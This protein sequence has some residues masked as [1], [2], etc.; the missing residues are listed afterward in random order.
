MKTFL[1]IILSIIKIVTTIKVSYLL[2]VSYQND[3]KLSDELLWW[4]VL[5]VFD[6]WILGNFT[7]LN[8]EKEL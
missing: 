1:T 5:L 2:Y 8:E 7:T 4:C 3:F 6:I